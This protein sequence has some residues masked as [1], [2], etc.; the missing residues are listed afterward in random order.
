MNSA[1]KDKKFLLDV[2]KLGLILKQ[3]KLFHKKLI[4]LYRQHS[5]CVWKIQRWLC[6]YEALIKTQIPTKN[7]S[8]DDTHKI[9]ILL[10]MFTN[11]VHSSE[12]WTE[13]L[14]KTVWMA[15]CCA[16]RSHYLCRCF[17][18][19]FDDKMILGQYCSGR[20]MESLL[21]SIRQ[22]LDAF[23]I[24]KTNR[25]DRA[26]NA[27]P[28]TSTYAFHCS[29]LCTLFVTNFETTS[30]MEWNIQRLCRARSI[31]LLQ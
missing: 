3:L 19:C 7:F 17:Q 25:F 4:T 18:V 13:N 26:E 21:L 2:E 9:L 24:H 15:P 20:M 16:R 22:W 23:D 8:I 29:T 31:V 6:I 30:E 5:I 27:F 1:M 11:F 28:F 14:F 12:Q 10:T